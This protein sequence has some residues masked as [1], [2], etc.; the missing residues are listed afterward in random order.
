M[1]KIERAVSKVKWFVGWVLEYS[2]QVMDKCGAI[3]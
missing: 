1:E 2:L 3:S